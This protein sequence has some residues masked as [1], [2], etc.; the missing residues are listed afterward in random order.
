MVHD[1]CR[2]DKGHRQRDF[3]AGLQAGRLGRSH[4]AGHR[5]DKPR[6]AKGL[7]RTLLRTDKQAC[8]RHH[9][10]HLEGRTRVLHLLVPH[11]VHRTGSLQRE[12]HLARTDG[13]QLQGRGVG[14][15]LH[16][17]HDGRHVQQPAIRHHRPCRATRTD[18]RPCHPRL[19]RRCARVSHAEELGGYR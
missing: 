10:R 2:G 3:Y 14:Q 13:H 5:P 15:R 19:P 4:R 16:D 18:S 6:G 17:R 1:S 12:A 11:G 7:S 8:Q 9:T